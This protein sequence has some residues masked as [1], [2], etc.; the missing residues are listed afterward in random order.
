MNILLLSRGKI[1]V[2]EYGG[3]ERVVWWLAKALHQKGHNITIMADEV[4]ETGFA[5]AIKFDSSRSIDSQIPEK[6]DIIHVHF[7]L[8]QSLNKPFIVTVHGNGKPKEIFDLNTVFV[9]KNHAERH[10]AVAFVHNGLDINEYGNVDWNAKRTHLLF[11]AQNRKEKNLKG[12]ISIAEK[13]KLPLQVIGSDKPAKKWY[14]FSKSYESVT[15]KGSLGGEQKYRIIN[16]SMALLFPVIWHEPFGLAVIE[17]LYFGSPVL[18]SK[19][20]ALPEIITKEVGFLSNNKDDYDNALKNINSYDRRRCNQYVCDTFNASIMAENYIKYYQEILENRAINPHV[21][22]S[23]IQ[24]N[25]KRF[26]F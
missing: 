12:C 8:R 14:D 1:P 26:R 16:K 18:A 20:G 21:P 13:A 25:S 24:S 19:Y 3:T 23:I 7:P 2:T 10:G 17:S 22:V 9:S 4:V 11:L 15:Y 5:K 6:I